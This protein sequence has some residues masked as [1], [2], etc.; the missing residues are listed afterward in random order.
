MQ[1]HKLTQSRTQARVA[2]YFSKD[3][4]VARERARG[5]LEHSK[6]QS[7]ARARGETRFSAPVRG[8]AR[9]CHKILV[10]SRFVGANVGAK[11]TISDYLIVIK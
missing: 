2:P 4:Q 5:R 1:A 11:N 10:T 8:C 3:T 6:T 7:Y 9:T